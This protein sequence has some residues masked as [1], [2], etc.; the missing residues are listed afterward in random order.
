MFHVTWLVSDLSRHK[1]IGLLASSWLPFPLYSLL[2]VLIG[3]LTCWGNYWERRKKGKNHAHTYTYAQTYSKQLL[4]R[5]D[6][7]AVII[8]E[9]L[10][11]YNLVKCKA[12]T[13]LC[14]YHRPFPPNPSGKNEKLKA[15]EETIGWIS[16]ALGMEEFFLSIN[17]GK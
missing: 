15:V 2:H 17:W 1:Y 5:V 12:N 7:H 6:Y 8:N 14:S 10:Y 11:F 16:Y 9:S 3:N 4:L 13:L